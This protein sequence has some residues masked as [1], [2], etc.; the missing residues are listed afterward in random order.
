MTEEVKI[1]LALGG[2]GARGLA[3]IGVL[4]V[5]ERLKIPISCIAGTSM[6]GLVGA[7]YANGFSSQEIEDEAMQVGQLRQFARFLDL[8]LKLRMRGLL[9]GGRI[10]RYMTEKL[11]EDLSFADLKLPLAV[12]CVD[13]IRGRQVIL[14]S[15]SVAAAVRATISVPA[16]F[17]PIEFGDYRLVDGGM[18]NNVPVDIVRNLGAD[19]VIAVD[20]LPNFCANQPGG[21]LITHP[22]EHKYAPQMI[23]E[24]YSVQLIMISALTEMQ[25]RESQPEILI[26]PKLPIDLGLFTGFDRPGEAI[27]AG[28]QAAVALMPQLEAL[29]K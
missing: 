3:H 2:G 12:V 27:T 5:L 16:I 18:L 13:L 23:K 19:V 29:L 1:G 15:G 21:P 26:R 9:K 17:E 10:Y 4:K 20:V 7:L 6:G 25:L 8:R 28:E 24:T 11:G 14:A 22:L